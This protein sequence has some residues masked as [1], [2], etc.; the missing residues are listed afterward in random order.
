MSKKITYNKKKLTRQENLYPA[1]P[2]TVVPPKIDIKI[3][4]KNF[5]H[6][7]FFEKKD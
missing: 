1:Q 3:D 2:T 7:W 5:N 4:I 6:Y